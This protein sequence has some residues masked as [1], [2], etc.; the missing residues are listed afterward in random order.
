[1]NRCLVNKNPEISIIVPVYN[2]EQYISRCIESILNQTFK[3]FELILIDDGSQDKSGEICD[4]YAKKDSRI[5]V[6]HNNNQGVSATRNYGINLS[7]GKYLMFCDSDDWVADNWCEELYNTILL[8]PDSW[9]TCNFF[10]VDKESNKEESIKNNLN[11]ISKLEK[12]DFYLVFKSGMSIY[13][14]NKIF[15]KE[16]IDKFHIRFNESTSLGE[17]VEFGINYLQVCNDIVVLNKYLYYY[18]KNHKGTLSS[19]KYENYFDYLIHFYKLRRPFI[20]DCYLEEFCND[21]FY[22]F[23]EA[24]SD[25]MTFKNGES[26]I[27]KLRYNQKAI[28]TKEFIECLNNKSFIIEDQKYTKLLKT[29]N[30]YIVYFYLYIIRYIKNFIKKYW[31]YKRV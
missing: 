16:K 31:N 26:L 12:L 11:E 23:S 22:Q 25:K 5:R 4:K 24:L 27:C 8:Y 20:K 7:K 18:L 28:N 19:K 9:I 21:Y 13:S 29:K 30:Y 10:S 17:D 6:F 14:W 1:M 2:T 15:D 3:D